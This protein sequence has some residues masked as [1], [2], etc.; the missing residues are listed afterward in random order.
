MRLA[1]VPPLAATLAVAGCSPSAA[2]PDTAVMVHMTQTNPTACGIAE[3]TGTI[4]S[5]TQNTLT[6]TVTDGMSGASV[7]CSVAGSGTGPYSVNATAMQPSNDVTL[8]IIIPSISNSA[9]ATSPAQGFVSYSSPAT[10]NPYQSSQTGC[11]FYFIGGTPEK[12]ATGEIWVAFTCA[13]IS[14]GPGMSSC[15]VTQ[16]FAAFEGCETVATN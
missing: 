4:G 8:Q 16:S 9:T 11:D 10:T 2:I 3:N 14:Y 5:V 1:L 6:S 12:V 7:Q 13:E 15:P